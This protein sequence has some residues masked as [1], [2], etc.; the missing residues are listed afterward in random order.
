MSLK[1]S[2][3]TTKQY[4]ADMDYEYSGIINALNYLCQEAESAKL[5]LVSLHLS[6]A[7]AELREYPSKRA[8]AG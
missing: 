6:I 2:D 8:N 4:V 7:I 3:F 1:K 5:A